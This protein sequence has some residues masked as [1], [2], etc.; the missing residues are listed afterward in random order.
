MTPKGL[1]QGTGRAKLQS[2]FPE[3]G[4]LGK[5]TV[6]VAVGQDFSLGCFAFKTPLEI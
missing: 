6:W 5:E 3:M 4:R 1:A 2:T